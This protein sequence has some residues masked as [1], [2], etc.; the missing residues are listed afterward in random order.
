[1]LHWLA[2][3]SSYGVSLP[4]AVPG[5]MTSVL[6]SNNDDKPSPM[7]Q[8]LQVVMQLAAGDFS[9]RAIGSGGDDEMDALAAGI[10]MLIEE[11][12]A[13]FDENA[14]LVRTLEQN[15]ERM[16]DQHRTIMSLSTPS[17]L[18]WK[19]IV[20]LPLIGMLDTTRAQ[21]LSG[22]LLNRVAQHSTDVVI[23]DVTGV[24]EVDGATVN[25]LLN[26]FAALRLL[27]AK[28]ILTGLG[29]ANARKMAAID[30]DMSAIAIRGSLHDGLKL[31]YSMTGRKVLE[32]GA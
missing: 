30:V 13:K 32:R 28:C 11:V 14:E 15:M 29:P 9:A 12:V 6:E 19:G 21:N 24:A 1:M 2:P 8:I 16:A 7:S 31:A 17:L 4:R 23:I 10:N 20:V 27:G 3:E 26:T 22:E 18:V 25:H 5:K